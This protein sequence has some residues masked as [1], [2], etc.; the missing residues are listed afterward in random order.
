MA[1]WKVEGYNRLVGTDSYNES[2]MGCTTPKP[3][4]YLKVNYVI[5]LIILWLI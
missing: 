2:L 1:E 3:N 4:T 5:T